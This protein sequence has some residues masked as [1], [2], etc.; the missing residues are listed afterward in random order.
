MPGRISDSSQIGAGVYANDVTCAVSCTGTG[1]HFIRGCVAY[2]VHA[3]MHYLNR[4][5]TRAAEES[6]TQS[7]Q[8]L[9][10]RGGVIAVSG[11]G[12][13]AMPFNSPGMYRAWVR[14]GEAAQAAIFAI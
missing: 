3:R 5:L 4:D 8:P 2:D 6:I 10:G 9:G 12:Q 14:E 1:E 13:L 11:D 7:L